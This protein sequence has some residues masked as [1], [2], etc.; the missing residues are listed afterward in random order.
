MPLFEPVLEI[1]EYHDG[2]RRG[3]AN[4]CGKPHTFT[5]RWLDVY[6]IED[7]PDLFELIPVADPDA[8]QPVLA[9]AEFRR[10]GSGSLPPNE[11]PI[12]EVFWQVAVS[13]GI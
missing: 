9:S 2:P 8:S 4:F 6:G 7:T 10:I 5:S 13:G 3:V 1:R 11:W 12:L